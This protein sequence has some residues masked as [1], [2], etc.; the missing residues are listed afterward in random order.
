VKKEEY[1]C[2]CQRQKKVIG[3]E[4]DKTNE[5]GYSGYMEVISHLHENLSYSGKKKIVVHNKETPQHQKS[6]LSFNCYWREVFE[7]ALTLGIVAIVG[8]V[9]P[10]TWL[11]SHLVF[12]IFF[13]TVFVIPG[14]RYALTTYSIGLLVSVYY[15]LLLWRNA[16]VSLSFATI[17]IFVEPFLLF[18]SGIIIEEMLRA[19]RYRL[20]TIEQQQ[21]GREAFWEKTKRRY[22]ATQTIN[23]ELEQ[24]L[25]G[26]SLSLSTVSEKMVY[27]WSLRGQE[28]YD[29]VLDVVMYTIN[30]NF[31]VLYMHQNGHMVFRARKEKEAYE[32]G[33]T[34]NLEL[35][36]HDPLISR[37]VQS[38]RVCTIH[39]LL[40]EGQPTQQPVAMMA[41][42][43]VDSHDQ[44]VGI[45]L[46]EDIPL[47]AFLP[48]TV[49][50]FESLLHM[51]QIA[52]QTQTPEADINPDAFLS[53]VLD[54]RM[55][56]VQTVTSSD[57][58]LL[59]DDEATAVL[60]SVKVL[61]HK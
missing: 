25:V 22:Q 10:S 1:C 21:I 38:R 17:Q 4:L 34:A 7:A 46:V 26:Q 33:K 24:R 52:M 48:S 12:C 57:V 59:M 58:E 3:S 29:A 47:F 56:A 32:Y 45:V 37:V 43:L 6:K 16:H 54:A 23:A 27:L 42:P 30:A 28:Q 9:L 53:S 5:K 13:L 14:R 61:V 35:D 60:S 36:I 11:Q 44:L 31:C 40:S 2:N 15:G 51:V 18:V 20:A 41:G 19:Q 39:D 49:Q 55:E 8:M 50:L